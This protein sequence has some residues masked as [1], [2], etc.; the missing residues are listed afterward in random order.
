MKS[1][2]SPT[3]VIVPLASCV[4]LPER[5][6]AWPKFTTAVP[7][8]HATVTDGFATLLAPPV[9]S[10][11]SAD[12]T[13]RNDCTPPPNLGAACTSMPPTLALVSTLV[14]PLPGLVIV[15]ERF[16]L[17]STLATPW[18]ATPP[19]GGGSNVTGMLV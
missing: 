13:V 15:I 17:A 7:L 2:V 3:K 4:D 18:A 9:P 6:V 1:F 19:A 5:F 16:P 12:T 10:T 14:Y 11:T 8:P